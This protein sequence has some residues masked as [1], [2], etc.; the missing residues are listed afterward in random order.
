[1]KGR[2]EMNDLSWLRL[3]KRY[4]GRL[5][6]LLLA[7][8][9]VFTEI[10]PVAVL[11]APEEAVSGDEVNGYAEAELI[12]E[13]SE[14]AAE[15]ELNAIPDGAE[16]PD[17]AEADDVVSDAGAGAG[18]VSMIFKDGMAQP[19]LKD[20]SVSRDSSGTSDFKNY[21]NTISG[22]VQ[23][24]TVY[25]ET[26]L[27]TDLDGRADLVMAVVQVPTAAV[28]GDYKAPVIFE[29]SPYFGG[30]SSD[31]PDEHF[32]PYVKPSE[33]AIFYYGKDTSVSEDM[34]YK[35][36]TKRTPSGN[37]TTL[38][39]ANRKDYSND[40]WY[41]SYEDHIKKKFEDKSYFYDSL[42]SYDYLLIR[43]FAVVESAGLGT[44]GSEGFET[45]G[46]MAEA[47]AFASVVEWIHGDRKAYTDKEKN[48]EIKAD[49]A[50]GKTAMEGVSYDGSL[51]Y[52]VASLE[53]AGLVTVVPECGIAS[54]YDY[55]NT[56]GVSHYAPDYDYI[57][58][59]ASSNASRFY[60]LLIDK[61]INKE[62]I[63]TSSEI[64]KLYEKY[65]DVLGSFKRGQD[66]LRG[67][68]GDFWKSRDFFTDNRSQIDVPALIV[69]GLQDYNVTNKQAE[70]MSEAFKTDRTILHLAAHTT[71][72][73]MTIQTGDDKVRWYKDLLNLWFSHWLCDQDNGIMEE[74]PPILAQSNTDGAFKAYVGWSD[75]GSDNWK[76]KLVIAPADK[77]EHKLV[78]A[79]TVSG[80][81]T[82]SAASPQEGSVQAELEKSRY[83]DID[84]YFEELGT[85]YVSPLDAGGDAGAVSEKLITWAKRADSDLTIN[86][87]GEV[88][89]RVRT[90]RVNNENGQ[91]PLL[92]AMLYDISD[93]YFDA[94]ELNEEDGL[95]TVIVQKDAFSYGGDQ[96]TADQEEYKTTPVKKHLITK[97]CVNLMDPGAAYYPETSSVS[98]DAVKADEYYDYTVYL[99]PTFYTVKEG[100]TLVL[101]IYPKADSIN[102][103]SDFIVDNSRSFACV[104]LNEAM[105]EG[106]LS[107]NSV[108]TATEEDDATL[109]SDII[110]KGGSK[111]ISTVTTEGYTK[112]SSTESDLWVGIEDTAF[113]SGSL[114]CVWQ[115]EAVTLDADTIH[116]YDGT[117]LLTPGA[118]YKISYQN[119]KKATDQAQ[120]VVKFTGSYKG[121]QQISCPMTIAK[122]SLDEKTHVVIDDVTVCATGKAIKPV[123]EMAFAYTGISIPA[124]QVK[125][126]YT[127]KTDK[128]IVSA[129]SIT[130]PGEYTIN[131]EPKNAKGNL[132]GRAEVDLTVLDA[133]DT[134]KL[135]AKADVEFVGHKNKKYVYENKNIIPEL[136][137]TLKGVNDGKALKEGTDYT[138]KAYRNKEP[139]TARLVLTA[140]SSNSLGIR[141]SRT[142][143]FTIT[144]GRQFTDAKDSGFYFYAYDAPYCISGA[145][146][147]VF[148]KDGD[149]VL[150]KGIDYTVRYSK[151]KEVTKNNNMAL[152]SI[153]G[154]GKYKGTVTRE[155]MV[156]PMDIRRLEVVAADKF[157]TSE[158]GYENPVV[159]VTDLKGKKLKAGRDYKVAV[160]QMGSFTADTAP[161]Y[162][163][164]VEG[165]GN[166]VGEVKA[167]YHYTDKAYDISK[168]KAKKI[169]PQKITGS[170]A[171][172]PY[173]ELAELLYFGTSQNKQQLKCGYDFKVDYYINNKK[174]GTAKVVL[175]GMG[176]YAGT[177]TV[178]F[179]IT[180]GKKRSFFGWLING[181]LKK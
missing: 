32:K 146:G 134:G 167:S 108:F 142:V 88:H 154:K 145:E 159:T 4:Y 85:E 69:A 111:K 39:H 82:V 102:S 180:D 124:S 177:K 112:H 119:N 12:E 76:N 163:V 101:Y 125:L 161:L 55:S 65:C 3:R 74:L 148:V 67:H 5:F 51:A 47:K 181:I 23:R 106:T 149:T 176:K 18:S 129:N 36:G 135:L 153:R 66:A 121:N 2:D 34:L 33:N 56:Q 178:T 11:A 62:K 120:L 155:F 132:T 13:A 128:S 87:S 97:G 126:S 15:T 171:I 104:P 50:S 7:M 52:E 90:C 81:G 14:E 25:V 9:L 31:I 24:F 70:L 72:D 94:Y 60:D 89:V 58:Y 64:Y 96:G 160:P 6:G 57:S 143:T 127:S 133:K 59:L 68:Y 169:A 151:N 158:K 110:Y 83:Y 37:I 45:C 139:G 170:E 8:A 95:A 78:S 123:P 77:L 28:N 48:I 122:A 91:L 41:Y 30:Q 118:D 80:S 173:S 113:Q 150:Q 130:L 140:V 63:D 174:T 19:I 84:D 54:W 43:G 27:D 116:V 49:W 172:L 46:S 92:G 79:N 157:G 147:E 73:K 38:E 105:K 175:K 22:N 141:G 156:L 20:I 10:R 165:I 138:V 71:P 75:I 131:I 44:R 137:V 99:N 152:A 98:K 166:Y 42:S 103:N 26:D 40:E 1:M 35:E 114:D 17:G 29:A 107:F 109:S 136:S 53:P 86:G 93:D 144:K 115:G 21:R 164:N 162:T 168:A 179:K 100:H 61:F 16:S 117:K